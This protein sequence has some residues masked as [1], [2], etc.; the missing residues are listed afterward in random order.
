M[1]VY[2]N[3]KVSI[4]SYGLQCKPGMFDN[5]KFKLYYNVSSNHNTLRIH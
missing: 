3:K 2:V 1:R 4:W 5:F